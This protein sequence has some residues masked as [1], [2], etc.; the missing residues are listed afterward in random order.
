MCAFSSISFINLSSAT[1]PD[2]ISSTLWSFGDGSFT[3]FFNPSHVFTDSG[4][5]NVLLTIVSS[6]GCSNN[7]NKTFK[8]FSTPSADFSAP[9]NACVNDPVLFVNNSFDIDSISSYSW[10]FGSSLQNPLQSFNQIGLTPVTLSVTNTGGCGDSVTKFIFIDP[11]S[12]CLNPTNIG[13]NSIWV[14]SD[15]VLS[16]ANF[17]DS[18][19]DQSGNLIHF[20]Q[21]LSSSRPTIVNESLLNFHNTFRFDGVDDY[22]FAGDKLDLDTSGATFFIVAK[23]LNEPGSPGGLLSKSLL[24]GAPNRYSFITSKNSLFSIYIDQNDKSFTTPVK[25]NNFNIYAINVNRQS[26]TISTTIVNDTSLGRRQFFS[27]TSG[28]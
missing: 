13:N 26:K 17:I 16:S 8:I 9:A 14:N 10:S 1:N 21:P 12:I 11:I 15:S 24:G 5:Y 18:I 2:T 6:A 27:I 25:S 4:T 3:T 22:M 7:I 23:S 28:V 20:Y 19:F